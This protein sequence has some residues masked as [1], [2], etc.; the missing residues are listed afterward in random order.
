MAAPPE[1]NTLNLAGT[2]VMVCLYA[3]IRTSVH[4]LILSP[5]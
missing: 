5:E 1:V 3:Q 4:G 2:Y